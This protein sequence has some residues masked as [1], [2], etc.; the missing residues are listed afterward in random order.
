MDKSAR[1]E[2]SL[3]L[4]FCKFINSVNKVTNKRNKE[5]K[6]MLEVIK[7]IVVKIL[8]DSSSRYCL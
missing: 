1:T 8:M 4:V 3:I 7:F 6:K 5:Y 2:K